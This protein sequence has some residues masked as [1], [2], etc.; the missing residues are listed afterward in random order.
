MLFILL[1]K[2]NYF[3]V[4][5]YNYS[6]DLGVSIAYAYAAL[7]QTTSANPEVSSIC[8]VK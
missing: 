5:L 6:Y 7:L 2:S 1:F 3:I 4:Y 8:D